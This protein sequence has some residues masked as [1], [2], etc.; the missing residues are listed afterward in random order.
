VVLYLPLLYT[1]KEVFNWIK[2]GK[3]TVDIRKGKPRCG[4]NIVFQSG[5]NTLR[6]K[7]AKKEVGQLDEILRL[8]NYKQAIPSAV[9]LS[10]AVD[11]LRLIYG[12][13]DGVFTAYYIVPLNNSEKG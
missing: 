3:K 5:P 4:E 13:C 2:Q 10:D 7:I 6:F 11:Y 12:V 9:V 1:R 8:D